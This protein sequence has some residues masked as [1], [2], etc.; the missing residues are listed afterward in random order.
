MCICLCR[1]SPSLGQSQLMALFRS[2]PELPSLG[3][4]PV[5]M[6]ETVRL[7][8][9]WA[10]ALAKEM[11]EEGQPL[12]DVFNNFVDTGELILTCMQIVTVCDATH[13]HGPCLLQPCAYV[14][15]HFC[16]HPVPCPTSAS[17][18]LAYS[19]SLSVWLQSKCTVRAVAHT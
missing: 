10:I 18:V 3:H 11:P 2:L 9:P 19:T 15:C 6:M 16:Y 5:T 12:L 4:L 14:L 17:E 13:H 8:T 1:A 7:Y